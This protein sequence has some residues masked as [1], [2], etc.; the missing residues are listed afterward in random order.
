MI[1]LHEHTS[2]YIPV[3]L[4]NSFRSKTRLDLK[5]AQASAEI[6]TNWVA[7]EVPLCSVLHFSFFCSP[8]CF[9]FF[10]FGLLKSENA[11]K[12]EEWRAIETKDSV[13]WLMRFE[14]PRPVFILLI[15]HH[16]LRVRATNLLRSATRTCCYMLIITGRFKLI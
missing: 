13:H 3:Q 9:S 4:L 5:L 8:L 11:E 10:I 15:S 1:G 16:K 7:S 6:S 12:P 14:T 2:L